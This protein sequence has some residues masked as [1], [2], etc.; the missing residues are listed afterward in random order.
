[1][2]IT[3]RRFLLYFF[4][5]LILFPVWMW[6]GWILTPNLSFNVEAV[7]FAV[8]DVIRRAGGRDANWLGVQLTFAW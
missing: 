2:K 5:F 4:P 8:S 6:L 3:K 7:H 1:M